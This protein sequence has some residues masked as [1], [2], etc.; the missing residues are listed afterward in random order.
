[1]AGSPTGT[2]PGRQQQLERQVLVLQTGVAAF[3]CFGAVGGLFGPPG[4]VR[5]WA[6]AWILGY[7]AAHAAYM[8][9]WRWRGR[10]SAKVE[11][12]TPAAEVTCITLAWVA[13]GQPY[14]PLWAVYLYALVGYSRRIHGT[15]Y[16]AVAFFIIASVAAGQTYLTQH[17]GNGWVDENGVTIVVMTVFMAFLAG[18]IGEAWR[19]AEGTARALAETD[20]L[21]GIANRRTFLDHLAV[22]ALLPTTQF[23]VLMLDLDDFK[24]LNDEHG[25]LHG[26]DVLARTAALL[27]ANLRPG[28]TVARYGGEEFVVMLP[29]ASLEEAVAIAER[30]RTAVFERTPTTVSIGCA[31]RLPAESAE[32]VVRRADD[33]LLAAKRTGKNVVVTRM[34]AAAA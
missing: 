26:D 34:P 21:T 4:P 32:G 2:M 15:D 20:P 30:L 6:V 29:G 5:D 11:S 13:I 14:S 16:L 22:L 24:K 3:Y 12:L 18:A 7:H 28:D 10:R 9:G 25:H 19:R 1:M 17:A 23:S 27:A 8:V 33:L 31:A